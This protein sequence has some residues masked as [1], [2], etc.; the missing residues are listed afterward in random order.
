MKHFE[1]AMAKIRPLS[2]QELDMYN[3]VS[4]KFGKPQLS[5]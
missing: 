4:N 5:A 1:E 2:R 3:N